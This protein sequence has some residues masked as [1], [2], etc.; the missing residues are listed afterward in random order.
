MHKGSAAMEKKIVRLFEKLKS[1]NLF[2]SYAKDIQAADVGT[3]ILVETALK[4]GDVSDIRVLF[5]CYNYERLYDIWVKRVVFDRR[6]DKLNFY[7]ATVFFDVDLNTVRYQR[8]DDDRRNKLE[9]LA[10]RD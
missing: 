8:A 9:R 5:E 2:W 7:L 4:Y 6:F 3:D 1:Q 10:S